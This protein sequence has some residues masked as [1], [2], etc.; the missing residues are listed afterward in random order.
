MLCRRGII[1][2]SA[3]GL[4]LHKKQIHNAALSTNCYEYQTCLLISWY[5]V[6][7]C[8]M[9]SIPC[10]KYCLITRVIETCRSNLRQS[11]LV[12]ISGWLQHGRVADSDQG[13]GASLVPNCS[14]AARIRRFQHLLRR[15]RQELTDLGRNPPPSCAAG[16]LRDDLVFVLSPKLATKLTKH[17]FTG[18]RR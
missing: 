17:I 16:P 5:P 10:W 2:L 11:V 12:R 6:N 18:K 8:S 3:H 9:Q 4:P 1:T 7:R 14:T 13:W 15:I